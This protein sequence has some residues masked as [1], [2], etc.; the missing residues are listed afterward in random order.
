MM[1]SNTAYMS[2]WVDVEVLSGKVRGR[3][4]PNN[5]LDVVLYHL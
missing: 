3:P 4:R 1:R 2:G 5:D